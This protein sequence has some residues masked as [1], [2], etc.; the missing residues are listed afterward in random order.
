VSISRDGSR[1]LVKTNEWGTEKLS[2]I[3]RATRRVVGETKSP[4]A[5]LALSWSPNRNEIAYLSAEGNGDNYHLFLWKTDEPNAKPLDGPMTNTA[6]QSIRWSPDGSRLA[7]LV[8]NNDGATIWIVDAREP[9]RSRAFAGHVRPLSDFEWSP[10]GLWIAAVFRNSPFTLEIINSSSGS[11]IDTFPIGRGP[12]SEIRHL[13]WAPSGQTLALAGRIESDFFELIKVD[14]SSRKVTP[15]ASAD[16]DILAPHFTSDGQRIIY[17]VSSDSQV[18]LF[19]TRCG[20]SAPERIWFRSGTAR[21]LRLLPNSV[22]SKSSL[23]SIVVLY[24]SLTEPPVLYRIPLGASIPELV[25]TPPNASRLRSN[26]PDVVPI[27]STDGTVIPTVFW[28][29]SEPSSTTDV[30]LVDVHGGPHLQQYRRWEFLPAILSRAG[31]DVLSPNYRGSAGYGYRFERLADMGTQIKDIISVCK[32]ARS[33]HGG[34]SRVILMGTSFGALLAASA[35]V[36]NPDDISGVILLSVIARDPGRPPLLRWISPLFCFHGEN[37]PQ[38]PDQAK[39]VIESFFG[40]NIFQTQQ[41]RWRVFAH[42][43]HVL[44]LTSSWAEVYTS[45]LMMRS[46][47]SPR[48]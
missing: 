41:S 2:V 28:R 1:I 32:Y 24:N 15:C 33:L 6:I 37:D 9:G 47:I 22:A 16:G 43:G 29:R 27:R 10:D 46:E 35:T 34:K 23:D 31:V 17:S 45:V 40:P 12:V 14:L 21:F 44:R 36:S 39:T 25:Y 26:A 38:P 42:E 5:H 20:H 8:G 18:N 13:S 48:K 4:N 19:T 30:V 11:L 3:D 7:Y